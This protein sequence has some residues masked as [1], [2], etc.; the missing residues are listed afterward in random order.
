MD[1]LGTGLLI[2]DDH[3]Q[4]VNEMDRP[5][6][7]FCGADKSRLPD[8]WEAPIVARQQGGTNSCAGH[9]EW[10]MFVFQNWVQT[11]ELVDY[12]PWYCYQKARTRGGF[13]GVDGGTS[14]RSTIESATLDGSCLFDLCPKLVLRDQDISAAANTDA[15]AHK[16]I[17]DSRVDLRIFEDAVDWL[18][19]GRAMIIGTAWYSGQASCHWVED[20]DVIQS[21]RFQGYHA[22][23][24]IGWAKHKGI[25]V[26]VILNSHG[27]SHGQRGRTIVTPEAWDIWRQ[28]QN[29]VAMGFGLVRERVPERR[30]WRQTLAWGLGT[31]PSIG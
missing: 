30:D 23:T 1:G 27:L 25:L 29:F 18:T 11:G 13:R 5:P 10:A 15:A 17:G 4:T 9:A 16:H 20:V 12:S 14:I 26:P 24:G 21:G 2:T 19:D 22:R 7:A 28:D 31:Q 3:L 8:A 6:K